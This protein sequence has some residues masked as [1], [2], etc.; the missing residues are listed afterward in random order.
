M[1][2][3]ERWLREVRIAKRVEDSG[4]R[5]AF[6]GATTAYRGA[7]LPESGSLKYASV[8]VDNGERRRLI[9][10]KEAEAAVG[11][12]AWVDGRLYLIERVDSLPG[13]KE[14][15]CRLL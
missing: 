5:E 15:V 14:L 12:G 7:C 9:L 11:D 4:S 10:P 2:L 6:S 13:Q 3:H 1:R 8:G